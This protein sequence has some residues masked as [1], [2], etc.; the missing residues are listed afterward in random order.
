MITVYPA[1]LLGNII[2]DYA[3]ALAL[4]YRLKVPLYFPM[5]KQFS[6]FRIPLHMRVQNA[7]NGLRWRFMRLMKPPRRIDHFD[8][9]VD[10]DFTA[11]WTMPAIAG[12]FRLCLIW[13]D[14]SEDYCVYGLGT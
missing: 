11:R 12:I 3:F 6:I 14:I 10:S 4:R 13:R 5:L 1:G 9:F 7:T 2:G 8:P